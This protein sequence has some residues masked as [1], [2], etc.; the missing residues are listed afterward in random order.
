MLGLGFWVFVFFP[1]E[2]H[3]DEMNVVDLFSLLMLF[4]CLLILRRKANKT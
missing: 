2:N 1:L 4:V 3:F